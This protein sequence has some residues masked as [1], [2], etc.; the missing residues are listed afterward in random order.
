MKKKT[1]AL[2]KEIKV[3]ATEGIKKIHKKKAYDE[4]IR[5]KTFYQKL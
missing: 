1:V 2:S 3:P 4:E 5:R